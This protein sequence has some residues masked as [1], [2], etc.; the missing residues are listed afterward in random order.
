M[1]RRGSVSLFLAIVSLVPLAGH[2]SAAGADP[3]EVR[4]WA[5]VG[6]MDLNIG[7]CVDNPLPPWPFMGLAPL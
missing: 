7:V 6:E 4:H 5:C 1:V 2:A 3:G